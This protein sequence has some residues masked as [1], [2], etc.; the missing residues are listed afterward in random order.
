MDLPSSP[1]AAP[2]RVDAT[3]GRRSTV[4]SPQPPRAAPRSRPAL[5]AAA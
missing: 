1:L 4:G 3:P 5:A 2:W